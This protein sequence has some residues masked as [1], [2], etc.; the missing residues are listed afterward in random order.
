M[1]VLTIC[2]AE[3]KDGAV[4]LPVR[5]VGNGKRTLWV[6]DQHTAFFEVQGDG[7][8]KLVKKPK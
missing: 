6:N 8:V 1:T 5:E 4:K 3:M 2:V 7:R